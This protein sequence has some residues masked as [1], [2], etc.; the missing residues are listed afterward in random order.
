MVKSE[1]NI[2]KFLHPINCENDLIHELIFPPLFTTTNL[3]KNG[4][5][6]L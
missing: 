4:K 5:L 2:F 6:R 3:S 1:G